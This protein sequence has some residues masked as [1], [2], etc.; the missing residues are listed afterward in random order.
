MGT[1]ILNRTWQVTDQRSHVRKV[2]AV[3]TQGLEDQ[4]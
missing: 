2:S 4:R 3:L 1:V